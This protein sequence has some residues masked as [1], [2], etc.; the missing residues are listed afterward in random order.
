ML[1][2]CEEQVDSSCDSEKIELTTW[3]ITVTPVTQDIEPDMDR[4]KILKEQSETEENKKNKEE[5]VTEWI[6]QRIKLTHSFRTV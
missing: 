3:D 2:R 1:L 4:E 6:C 5:N